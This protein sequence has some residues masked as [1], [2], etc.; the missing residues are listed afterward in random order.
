V[1][2]VFAPL[3]TVLACAGI[4][5]QA[6]G[7]ADTLGRTTVEQRVVPGA[8]DGFRNL[9]LG[10][11]EGYV[12]RAQG[13]GA[14]K[15]GREQRRTSLLYLG[16]LSDFQLADEESPSRVE[17]ID[18]GP[19]NAA[20]RPWEAMEPQIDDATIRQLNAFAAA[21]P[22]AA[23]DG[24]HRAMDLTINTGDAADSQ[25]LNET[26]WVR[27]LMEGGT[28]NPGSGTDPSTSPDPFC[29]GAAPLMPDA[30]TPSNYTGVQDY[31]DYAE[32]ATP[33]FYD[34]DSPAAAFA[35]WPQYPGLM[36]R[37]Q[38]PFEAAGLD[39]PSYIAF[40]NH[41]GLV[42]GNAA[43][44]A[45]YESVATGCVKPMSPAVTD[46]DTF[47]NAL[48][49]LDP[50]N[51]QSLLLTSPSS[52][53]L[54]PP[55][56]KRQYV[57]KAQYKA[58]F[59]AGT[60]ADGHGFGLVDPAEEQA[61][62]GAAG[63][64]SRNPVPGIRMI[65][66]DTLSEAGVVGPSA[67]GHIDDP[68]F[69][70]LEDQLKAATQAD[71][72]VILF[73]HH[74]I[75]SLTADVPDESAPPCG[76]T[77]SHGH[78]TNPGCDIDPRD[79]SPIH[80]G[81]DLEE[82]L[83]KYPHVIAWVAGHS[84]VNS[85]EPHANPDGPGGFW[86]IRVAAEAD[87]PM[88]SRLV[89]LFDNGD[90][91]LS[92][93]GTILDF[94]GNATAPAPGSAASFTT[95][96]LA[97]V[98]R[99]LAYNDTQTGARACSEGPCGEGEADDRNV[100][101]LVADPRTGGGGGGGGSGGGPCANRI[102][103]TPGADRLTGNQGG[104][105]IRGRGGN[106]RLHGK[107]GDDCLQGG[108]GNDRIGGGQGADKLKGGGGRDRIS[109]RDGERDTVKCGAGRDRVAADRKDKISKSCERV[110]RRR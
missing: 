92:L 50:A 34:P 72:L 48:G 23:G 76:G 5:A 70:W 80:L 107:A 37:A 8:G 27:T 57:S 12:V 81:D 87:W 40:G 104:D 55:D 61:S 91:T 41:D 78:G 98:G 82:L 75:P 109:A 49:A 26:E 83:F 89:E 28:L 14:A 21:S 60:Q 67:D 85:V 44:N 93:F 103:G 36:D 108:R 45:S 102:A 100:E 13:V 69:R 25:Q 39:V 19:Y 64:Y 90:G 110:K 71:E 2:A 94:A 4:V 46:P 6:S 32:G 88:Q 17:F 73:S 11:G 22:L 35:A 62:G 59:K 33:Q 24:S 66:L 20:W 16:Q 7:A 77:D 29:A 95:E 9:G 54:V 84:H 42:Q 53:A 30:A 99:T 101:L 65:A 18:Y 47:G 68:Q 38:Q 10:A 96:D 97:S 31:D 43:A 1:R 86:S 74:A 106:D 51:L 15:P 58:V 52:V 105:V 79:S 56:P 3:A 63:Y